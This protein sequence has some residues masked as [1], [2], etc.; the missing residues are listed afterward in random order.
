MEYTILS[1]VASLV[2]ASSLMSCSTKKC[3]LHIWSELP[4]SGRLCRCGG[5]LWKILK[6]KDLEEKAY[7]WEHLNG[8]THFYTYFSISV[9]DLC[10]IVCLCEMGQWTSMDANG[11]LFA[12][13]GVRLG[14]IKCC[15]NMQETCCCDFCVSYKIEHPI[16]CK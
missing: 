3:V 16:L 13:E 2:S 14:Q 12:S 5:S 1:T 4:L 10:V 6:L 9:F 7:G 15:K 11:I 8:F